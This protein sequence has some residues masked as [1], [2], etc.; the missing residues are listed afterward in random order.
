M[1]VS[2]SPSSKYASSLISGALGTAFSVQ[3]VETDT[4]DLV[5]ASC[6]DGGCADG[7][8][9]DCQREAFR[10]AAKAP[11]SILICGEAWELSQ[12]L[13]TFDVVLST[14][15]S[16]TY[17]YPRRG[18]GLWRACVTTNRRTSYGRH[19]RS[20]EKASPTCIIDVAR[21]ANASWNYYVK[22][23]LRS[24]R[25]EDVDQI[26]TKTSSREDLVKGGTTTR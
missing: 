20:I 18:D 14:A 22:K 10:V 7:W 23:V 3:I 24:M 2:F 1:A 6:L 16:S 13:S 5:V 21:V 17:T 8:S 15:F 9:D 11:L 25:S 26:A 12:A 19:Q 4:P